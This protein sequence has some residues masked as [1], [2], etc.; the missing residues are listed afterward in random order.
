MM[1]IF[2]IYCFKD[3]INFLLIQ[4]AINHQPTIHPQVDV[5][6]LL[7][8]LTKFVHDLLAPV[9]FTFVSGLLAVLAQC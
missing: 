3:L 9:S 7:P 4:I 5:A 8:T 6:T 1:K 2:Q